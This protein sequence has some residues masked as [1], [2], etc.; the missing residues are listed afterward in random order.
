MNPMKTVTAL[1]FAALAVAPAAQGP[2]EGAR[3][4]GFTDAGK[5]ALTQQMNAAVSSG[6]TPGVVEMVV[7]RDGV[8]F[9]GAAK[10]PVNSIFQIA[11]MTK[12]V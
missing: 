12:P 9:E 3:A 2:R 4:P 5:A 11:S 7:N 10:L 6:D 1:M 8:L